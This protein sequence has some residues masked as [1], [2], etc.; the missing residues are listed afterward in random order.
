[1]L[2]LL[3]SG[4]LTRSASRRVARLIPNPIVR[5]LAMA[6]TGYAITRV[7]APK[8]RAAVHSPRGRGLL[9]RFRPA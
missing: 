1:M 6:A 7:M 2:R 9:G 4:L 8:A 5:T 3:A